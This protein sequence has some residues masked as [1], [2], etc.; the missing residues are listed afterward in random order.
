MRAAQTADF[1]IGEFQCLRKLVLVHGRQNYIRISNMIL[2]FFYKNLLFT[3]PQF[4]FAFLTGYSGQSCFD[5]YYIS[6]Y[7]ILFTAW[8]LMVTGSMDWD[9]NTKRLEVPLMPRKKRTTAWSGS[10]GPST[11]AFLSFTRSASWIPCSPTPTSSASWPP[12]CWTP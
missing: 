11:G 8:P 4:F 6:L 2:Y 9:L 12:P 5:D 7:N 1:A 3:I 10:T